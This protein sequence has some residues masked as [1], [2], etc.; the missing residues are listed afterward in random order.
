MSAWDQAKASEALVLAQRFKDPQLSTALLQIIVTRT[1]GI[2]DAAGPSA[3][4]TNPEP[5]TD[6]IARQRLALPPVSAELHRQAFAVLDELESEFSEQTGITVIRGDLEQQLAQNDR[7]HATD[8][9]QR[10]IC[11][12]L[13]RSNQRDTRRQASPRIR[14]N[15]PRTGYAT[16]L[17]RRSLG[18]LLSRS[19]EDAEHELDIAT[20]AKAIGQPVV[21]DAAAMLVLT[22]TSASARFEGQFPQIQIPA[23]ALRDVYRATADIRGL[24]SSSP[25]PWAG[26]SNWD[27]CTCSNTATTSSS[28][29]SA[30]LKPSNVWQKDSQHAR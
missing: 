23:A 16:L 7:H 19:T 15:V 17:I 5:G 11:R 27:R 13:P 3:D 28:A 24:A 25:A 21:I 1:H 9:C 26:T 12:S 18:A 2:N 8:S 22:G 4:E 6:L 29:S 20:A 14:G 10:H 30:A